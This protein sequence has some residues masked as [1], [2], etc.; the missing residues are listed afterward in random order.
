MKNNNKTSLPKYIDNLTQIATRP[1]TVQRTEWGG[2]G[3][4]S[5]DKM[6][7]VAVPFHGGT[8]VFYLESEDF[9]RG[10]VNESLKIMTENGWNNHLKLYEEGK[11]EYIKIEKEI[12]NTLE[13]QK[14][15]ANIFRQWLSLIMKWSTF[16]FM[17]FALESYIDPEFRKMIK[18]VFLDNSDEMISAISSP[19]T[20]NA[21][22]EMRM[23]MCDCVLN[24]DITAPARLAKKW[25]WYNEYSFI[26]P[27][28]DEKYFFQELNKIDKKEAGEEKNKILND[29]SENKEKYSSIIKKIKDPKTK[30]LAEII[31]TYTFLRTD[32]I[33][34]YK[35]GQV[36]MRK[37]YDMIANLLSKKTG[38]KWE[39]IHVVDLLNDE[40]IDFLDNNIIPNKKEIN[41]RIGGDYIYIIDEKGGQIITNRKL[42]TE[43]QKIINKELKHEIKGQ[44]AYK[45]KVTGKV[46]IVLAKEDLSKV[47]NGDIL[48]ARITM[49]DYTPTM[50]ISSA[51]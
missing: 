19:S 37:I 43:A 21:Y 32:R 47:K 31:H 6:R 26:E 49:P 25:G 22:Q 24:S 15:I 5:I 13:D 39:R 28:Y 45:G 30:L 10:C 9:K 41:K 12:N 51:L 27:L 20:I 14:N 42:I 7:G 18:E 11:K 34:I 29:S 35:K 8:R 48:V 44:T 2:R 33:D 50:R 17:P 1:M 16:A 3:F 46:V 4:Y 38:E 40:I 23:E 36:M